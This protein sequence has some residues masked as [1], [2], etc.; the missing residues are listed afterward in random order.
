MVEDL[1]IEISFSISPTVW[2][3]GNIYTWLRLDVAASARLIDR[4]RDVMSCTIRDRCCASTGLR[5]IAS[6]VA[7]L[8]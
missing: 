6:G 7:C 1:R 4:R 8:G 2:Y 5:V 3:A